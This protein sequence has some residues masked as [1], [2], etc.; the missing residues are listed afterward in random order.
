VALA[1]SAPA[2]PAAAAAGGASAAVAVLGTL[3]A[4]AAVAAGIAFFLPNWG[5]SV[6]GRHI[7]PADIIRGAASGVVNG[8]AWAGRKVGLCASG[9]SYTA[10]KA[11]SAVAS[12][13]A[14]SPQTGAYGAM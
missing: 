2:A 6:A 5:F 7:V 3:A 13:T 14:K 10:P 11:Y 4:V 12:S 8:A 1:P 9:A